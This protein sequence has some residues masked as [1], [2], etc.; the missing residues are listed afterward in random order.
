MQSSTER[1]TQSKPP[2][3]AVPREEWKGSCTSGVSGATDRLTVDARLE[4]SLYWKLDWLTGEPPGDQRGTGNDASGA[5]VQRIPAQLAASAFREGSTESKPLYS[6]QAT[7]LLD[8][9]T[10]V[11][12]RNIGL[13]INDIR[14][15]N[16]SVRTAVGGAAVIMLTKLRHLSFR[17]PGLLQLRSRR[18]WPDLNPTGEKREIAPL[19]LLPGELVEIKS[20]AAI[21]ATLDK[22]DPRG[23]R[24]I[25]VCS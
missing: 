12:S 22:D 20:Q 1:V 10:F 5:S 25:P 6:C 9:S 17:L 23:P 15:G 7:E 13:W 4:S 21:E 16:A 11:S 2:A 14:S 8:A 18:L 19:G 24:L 3:E